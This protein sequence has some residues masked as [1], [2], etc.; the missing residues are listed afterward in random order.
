MSLKY[1]LFIV[2]LSGFLVLPFSI[3]AQTTSDSQTLQR[4][5]RSDSVKDLQNILKTDPSI[6]PQGL[7]TGFFGPMT[8]NAVKRLQARYGLPQTGIVNDEMF[9]TIFPNNV[10]LKV[11]SPNGGESWDKSANHS[12]LWQVT[13]G[14]IIRNGEE[15]SPASSSSPTA[16]MKPSVPPF[17]SKISIDLVRDSAPYFRYHIGTP[18]LYQTQYSWQVPD[19][20]SNASDYRAQIS[21]GGD[22]PCLESGADICPMYFPRYSFS[23]TSDNVFSITG[24]GISNDKIAKLKALIEQIQQ[25]INNLQSQLQ[26]LRQVVNSL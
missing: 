1:L 10:Q 25:Q 2:V 12:I 22:V 14:P 6:Y 23:D 18:D 11:I 13:I 4:G 16:V 9:Q 17:F 19:S 26:S 15:L 8:E 3:F 24:G 7:V 21:V 5:V 20:I